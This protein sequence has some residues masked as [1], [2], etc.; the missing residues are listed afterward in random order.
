MTTP[1]T[2]MCT[3]RVRKE[4]EREFSD[5][6]GRHWSVLREQELVTDTAPEAF[7]GAGPD[8]DPY[9]VEVF[10]WVN[11]EAPDTAHHLPAVA[12]IWEPMGMCCAPRDGLPP[13]E[14]HRVERLERGA[15]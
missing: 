11:G 15:A 4:K 10:E 8:G 2:V 12:S 3:Y 5:L 14:F 7:R 13:M 6:L 9:F 1:M